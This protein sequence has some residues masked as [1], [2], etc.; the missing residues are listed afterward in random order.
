MRVFPIRHTPESV[1][2]PDPTTLLPAL[3]LE[4]KQK[5]LYGYRTELTIASTQTEKLVEPASEMLRV[6]A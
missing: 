5:L 6:P 2:P 1:P 3:L 4:L